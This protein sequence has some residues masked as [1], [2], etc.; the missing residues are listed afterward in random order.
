MGVDNLSVLASITRG[1]ET[2]KS[3]DKSIDYKYNDIAAVTAGLA[4]ARLLIFLN[5]VMT[6]A[7]LNN[8]D[9]RYLKIHLN[10]LLRWRQIEII[11]Y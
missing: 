2:Q 1:H 8:G 6:T 11:V 9:R 7:K 10:A 5:V 3:Q 4:L